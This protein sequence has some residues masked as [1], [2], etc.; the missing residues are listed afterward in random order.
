MQQ[1][2]GKKVNRRAA[3]WQRI[4]AW[5]KL[6]GKLDNHAVRWCV[7]LVSGRQVLGKPGTAAGM[8]A[9][10]LALGRQVL[11]Q[12]GNKCRHVIGTPDTNTGM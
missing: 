2:L 11:G 3:D 9:V 10:S 7:R 6:W 5:L 12:H 1:V 4:A 8:C